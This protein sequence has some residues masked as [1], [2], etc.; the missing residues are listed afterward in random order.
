MSQYFI[1]ILGN[2]FYFGN[3]QVP[4]FDMLKIFVFQKKKQEQRPT[5][6][7]LI[8]LGLVYLPKWNFLIK[9]KPIFPKKTVLWKYLLIPTCFCCC[10]MLLRLYHGSSFQ[11]ASEPIS[12]SV[13]GHI[14]LVHTCVHR[15]NFCPQL[16]MLI[17][18]E[19]TINLVHIWM[20]VELGPG[21]VIN[22]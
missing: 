21:F 2:T 18:V 17:P 12:L 8:S 1:F 15:T 6:F 9:T 7:F 19:I 20:K 11:P 5:P 16:C 3:M 22:T 14:A 13:C 10:W 4:C